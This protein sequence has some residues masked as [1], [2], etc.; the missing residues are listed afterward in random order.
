MDLLIII[1]ILSFLYKIQFN[2]SKNENVGIEYT[3]YLRGILALTIVFC[4]LSS[5]RIQIPIFKILDYV[6]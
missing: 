4:H 3:K 6:R 1:F 5:G 2:K